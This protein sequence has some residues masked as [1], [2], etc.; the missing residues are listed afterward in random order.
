[1]DRIG[2]RP[3]SPVTGVLRSLSDVTSDAVELAEL[4]WLLAQSDLKSTAEVAVRPM[5]G[6]AMSAAM[7]IA[8][9]PL[10]AFGVAGW[11]AEQTRL[12]PWQAQV[13]VGFAALLLAAIVSKIALGKLRGAYREMDRSRRELAKNIHWLKQLLRQPRS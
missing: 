4:Q 3:T 9:L 13:V 11:L 8:A 6:I 10:I 1:M 2:D 12:T 5:M 7:L